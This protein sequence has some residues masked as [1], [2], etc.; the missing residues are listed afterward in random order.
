MIEILAFRFTGE[1]LFRN[2]VFLG[3]NKFAPN[4]VS[5]MAIWNGFGGGDAGVD[6]SLLLKP[7]DGNVS[8]AEVTNFTG[9][10][11]I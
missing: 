1:L 3:D 2:P 5:P 6:F 8:R 11:G 7:T 10:S 9:N 4:S